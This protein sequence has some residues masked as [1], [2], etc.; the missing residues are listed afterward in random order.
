MEDNK[1][2]RHT[3]AMERHLQTVLISLVVGAITYSA[4]YFFNDKADKAVLAS[5]LR[6]LTNQV[7]EMR[8]E[9][10]SMRGAFASQKNVDDHEARI[11]EIERR[12]FGSPR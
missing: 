11:R 3:G 1:D 4:A 12:L 9:V 7:A 6:A 5:E 8:G 10:S 2:R